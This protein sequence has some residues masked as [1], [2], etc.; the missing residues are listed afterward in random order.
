[1]EQFDDFF[2]CMILELWQEDP[3][4]LYVV[5]KR[6][7]KGLWEVYPSM[8]YKLSR[9]IIEKLEVNNKLY[10]DKLLSP[11]PYIYY[12]THCGATSYKDC[13][14]NGGDF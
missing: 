3:E 1:M 12:C 8:A 10:K 6:S 5:T 7:F 4:G 2:T 11:N 9:D 13:C 14:H